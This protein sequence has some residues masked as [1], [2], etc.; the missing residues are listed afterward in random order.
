MKQ[1]GKVLAG[2]A[3]VVAVVAGVAV[4]VGANAFNT[5][6]QQKLM[7]AEDARTRRAIDALKQGKGRP[8]TAGEDSWM[9]FWWNCKFH[10]VKQHIVPVEV[11]SPGSPDGKLI[12]HNA[13]TTNEEIGAQLGPQDPRCLDVA[14][15]EDALRA[16]SAEQDRRNGTPPELTELRNRSRP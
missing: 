5:P 11:D 4:N 12:I 6:A 14:P 8:L 1:T 16:A 3:L 10:F 2:A 15:S 9:L 7:D 13:T